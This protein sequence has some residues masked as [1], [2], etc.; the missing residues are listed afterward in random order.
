MNANATAGIKRRAVGDQ[1]LIVFSAVSTMLTKARSLQHDSSV[2][3]SRHLGV[4]VRLYVTS[5]TKPSANSSC[6]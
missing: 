2:C 4:T 1:L 3:S 6:R 5:D